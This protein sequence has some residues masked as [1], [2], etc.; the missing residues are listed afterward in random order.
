MNLD[1]AVK[2]IMTKELVSVSPDAPFKDVKSIFT[3]HDFHHIPVI[4][5]DGS[6]AGIISKAD[7]LMN[8][9]KNIRQTSGRTWNEKYYGS[10][11]AKDLMVENPMIIDPDDT[12]GLAA[13]IFL[14]NKLHALPIVEDGEVLGIV[15]AHD[16]LNYVFYKEAVVK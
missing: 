10:L 14:S 1:I 15:T 8:L 13:D 7:W 16:L 5:I 6:L 3:K 9:N 2:K 4:N 12:V 11:T